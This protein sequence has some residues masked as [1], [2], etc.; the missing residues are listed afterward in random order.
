MKVG[1][2]GV[3]LGSWA[4]FGG[5][6]YVLDVG[7]GTGLLALMAAQRSTAAI[8]A[9]EI[10]PEA[11]TDAR[12]NFSESAWAARLSLHAT[13]FQDFV[14]LRR[15]Q[16]IVSNP[17][18][19][20]ETPRSHDHKRVTARHADSLSLRELIS[21]SAVLLAPGGRISLVLPASKEEALRSLARENRLF[22]N[23]LAV[24]FPDSGK[25]AHR[26]LAELGFAEGE[27]PRSSIF[28]RERAGG[29]YTGQYR[30]L[31]RDF[32]LAF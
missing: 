22:V 17:P 13:S 19:F 32:Y 9:V 5:E 8:D 29:N 23:R 31:T 14:S 7:T 10:E 2:D 24:V 6:E 25:P 16:H 15:Y 30:E 4:R 12:N 27:E 11:A 3:L 21:K 28:I 1:I 20:D 18:F 26:I